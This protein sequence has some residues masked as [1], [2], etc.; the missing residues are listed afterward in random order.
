MNYKLTITRSKNAKC[1]YIQTTYRKKGG[2]LS[3]KTVKK[4]GNEK[5][6]IEKYGVEDAEAWAR[7]ELERMRQAAREE[8]Q[9]LVMELHPDRLIDGAERIFNGGDVFI[10]R[11]ATM[12]GLRKICG[13]ISQ[14]YRFKFNLGDYLIRMLTSRILHPGSK[15]SDFLKGG[16]YVEDKELRL[17]NFY[18]SLDVLG[19]QMN[20]IQGKIYRNT[21]E[22]IGRNTGVIY[23]DCT[24]VFLRWRPTMT[25]ASMGIPR[26]ID[27]IHW[28]R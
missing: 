23:Y 4:L 20:D 7:E 8:K 6:I 3:S 2:K 14:S 21:L 18:R 28:C 5:S 9:G 26:K 10:E 22:S 16:R 25:S 13:E 24:N 27:P 15:L 11:V 12:L 19:S 1:F 17:E